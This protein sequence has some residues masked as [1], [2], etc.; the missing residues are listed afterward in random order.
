[1]PKELKPP[2][3][4]TEFNYDM[5]A[6]SNE[7]AVDCQ[8]DP[9]GKSLAQQHFKDE[10]DINVIVHRFGLTGELPQGLRLPTYGDYTGIFDFQTAM[11]AIREANV[12]FMQLPAEIRAR[13]DNDPQKYLQFCEEAVQADPKSA[14]HMEAV[15]LGLITPHVP[16]SNLDL[17]TQP[18]GGKKPETKPTE[19][20]TKKGDTPNAPE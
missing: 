13:F 16:E 20:K 5:F 19:P 8:R 7:S 3:F 12:N 14:K 10:C 6:A 11:N 9:Q 4:R 1:M 18:E 17:P 15:E 2:F